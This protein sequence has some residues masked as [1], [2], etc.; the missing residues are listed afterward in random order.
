MANA[1][2]PGRAKL[3]GPPSLR[4]SRRANSAQLPGGGGGGLLSEAGIDVFITLVQK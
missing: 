4:P 3:A 2:L 1:R